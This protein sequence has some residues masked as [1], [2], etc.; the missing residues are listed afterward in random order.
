MLQTD[1]STTTFRIPEKARRRIVFYHPKVQLPSSAA[2]GHETD[3]ELLL[4]QEST[5]EALPAI[6]LLAMAQ[7][8]EAEH[9]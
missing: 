5:V 3:S 7:S 4:A 8:K 9:T 6:R 2:A 1:S